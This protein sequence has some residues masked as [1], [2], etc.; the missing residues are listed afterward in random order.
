MD[1]ERRQDML[2]GCI[3]FSVGQMDRNH[4]LKGP[5]AHIRE[6]AAHFHSACSKRKANKFLYTGWTHAW[7]F[8]NPLRNALR[9]TASEFTTPVTF[10]LTFN[11][12]K[13]EATLNVKTWHQKR[14]M[15]VS[16]TRK[17]LGFL[18]LPCR[19]FPACRGPTLRVGWWLTQ[20]GRLA[21]APMMEWGGLWTRCHDLCWVLADLSLGSWCLS[22]VW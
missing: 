19:S 11:P 21:A 20:A 7:D 14:T 17:I 12:T 13:T 10:K 22:V 3:F 6:N 8:K 15:N 5:N 9:N 16:C 18:A 4:T 2:L 1:E